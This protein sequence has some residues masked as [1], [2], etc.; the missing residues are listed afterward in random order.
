MEATELRKSATPLCRKMT[1]E[2]APKKLSREPSGADWALEKTPFPVFDLLPRRRTRTVKLWLDVPPQDVRNRIAGHVSEAG[3]QTDSLLSLARSSPLQREAVLSVL[4]YSL[5]VNT[6]LRSSDLAAWVDV[7]QHDIRQLVL[8]LH[9]YKRL[10]VF[11]DVLLKEYVVPKELQ[12]SVFATPAP[13]LF[14]APYLRRIEVVSGP[15]VVDAIKLS[16]SVRHIS[17]F[18]QNEVDLG[19]PS[20]EDI[21]QALASLQQ[22]LKSLALTCIAPSQE[23]CPFHKLLQMYSSG[24][25]LADVCPFLTSLSL[26]C[27]NENRLQRGRHCNAAVTFL[28]RCLPTLRSLHDVAIKGELSDDMIPM[29]RGI[30]SVRLLSHKALHV[31]MKL[32]HC[33]RVL[34]TSEIVHPGIVEI[35]GLARCVNLEVLELAL[36]KGAEL[37]FFP[38]LRQLKSL[39]SL[40]L[41][42]RN[43]DQFLGTDGRLVHQNFPQTPNSVNKGDML[44]RIVEDAPLLS[45]LS[46]I[47]VQMPVSPMVTIVERMGKRLKHLTLAFV[48]ESFA[49][50]MDRCKELPALMEAIGE[51]VLGL[52]SLDIRFHVRPGHVG[53]EGWASLR[54]QSEAARGTREQLK[55]RVLFPALRR[56]QRVAPMLD[57]SG[58]EKWIKGWP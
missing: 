22:N 1:S 41:R 9:N 26:S 54:T 45:E 21:L 44:L 3:R 31:A 17:L 5:C 12:A 18:M 10:N 39:R 13:T 25:S 28:W 6:S 53:P 51:Y 15:W 49:S 36:R 2:S 11:P 20:L 48:S 37:E 8:V 4:S 47:D 24:H 27:S 38:A 34:R 30:Q 43:C 46:L 32:G 40:T 58:V 56:L 42:W 29:L 57:V 23:R 55:N 52:R 35:S 19:D 7:F 16:S 14:S 50:S 33:V